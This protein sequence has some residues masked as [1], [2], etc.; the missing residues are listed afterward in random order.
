[1]G[2]KKADARNPRDDIGLTAAGNGDI[3]GAHVF[4]SFIQR[5]LLSLTIAAELP[6]P[7]VQR[8]QSLRRDAE[9][10][11]EFI[12]G[13]KMGRIGPHDKPR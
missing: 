1:M 6:V 5:E 8:L 10:V 9:R 12:A 4:V 11:A 2:K 7:V 13:Y 3:H